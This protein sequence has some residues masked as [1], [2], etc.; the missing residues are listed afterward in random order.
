MII[1]GSPFV[2]GTPNLI[3]T[4]TSL[5]LTSSLQLC[6]D[7]GDATSFTSGQTWADVSGNSYH[8]YRGSSSGS[9]SSD[10]TF[11]GVAGRQSSSEY[12]SSDGG[13]AFWNT[14]KHAFPANWHKDNATFT[15]AAWLYIP[16]GSTETIFVLCNIYDGNTDVGSYVA[17]GPGVGKISVGMSRAGGA[18][19]QDI[20]TAE[21]GY[22]PTG[23]WLFAAVSFSEGSGASFIR[24]NASVYMLSSDTYVSP[25]S[26]APS[27][28]MALWSTPN[29]AGTGVD[30]STAFLPDNG[31][32]IAEVVAWNR[33]LSQSEMEGLYNAR[34]GKFGL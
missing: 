1:L 17:V 24:A 29:S 25:S 11:N 18:L 7:A 16:N 19:I 12:F 8:F 30:T 31:S 13:D 32:R 20:S 5:S 14:A 21:G 4:I 22:V 27:K 10:P 34:K 6:L 9:E 15:A 3:D 28:G 2:F 26:A 23:Q 33:A